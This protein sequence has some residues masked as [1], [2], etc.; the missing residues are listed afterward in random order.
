MM[1]F[2]LSCPDV[3]NTTGNK[4]KTS[5]L[6]NVLILKNLIALNDQQKLTI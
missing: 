4:K 3:V 6:F 2:I 5:L 1:K